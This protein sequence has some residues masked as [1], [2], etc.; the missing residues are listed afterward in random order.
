M[1]IISLISSATEIVNSLQCINNLVGISHECDYPDSIKRLPVC[2]EPRFDINGKSIE[3][4]Q[5]IKSLLQE[6]LSIYRVKEDTIGKLKPD[7][8]IT[9]SQCDVCAVNIKD[10][11]SALE[12]T[13]GINPKIISLSPACLEDVW[14]DILELGIALEKES[15]AKEV[16]KNIKSDISIISKKNKNK[17]PVSVGCIEWIEPLMFA[18]NWVPEIVQIAGGKSF[19]GVAGKHS[20]WSKYEELYQHDPDKIIFMPCG[21]DMNKTK[22]ELSN[23]IHDVRWKN[24]EAVKTGNIY[25]TDGN[26]YFNRPGPR[27]LDSIKI[28]DDIINNSN[29]YNL[30]ND[31]WKRLSDL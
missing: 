9:Q 21:Y 2:S 4:D 6:A 20:N 5:S 12:Q 18:G 8:I 29:I 31:G 28:M 17:D 10:V 13:I 26:Q 11:R 30:K 1:R 15:K 16:I 14:N 3:V 23:L 7:I 22:V 25:L 24:L 27:L 19:F